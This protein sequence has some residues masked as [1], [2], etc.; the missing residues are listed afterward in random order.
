M[1]I[2]NDTLG[3]TNS[4]PTLDEMMNDEGTFVTKCVKLIATWYDYFADNNRQL[5]DD[6]YFLNIDQWSS[7]DRAARTLA[8]KPVLQINYLRPMM[9]QM[10]GEQR[11]QDP[12]PITSPKNERVS[13]EIVKIAKEVI[14]NNFYK[15]NAPVVF[16]DC[17]KYMISGGYSAIFHLMEYEPKTFNKY[18]KIIQ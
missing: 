4:Y 16:Q 1:A 7:Q 8:R 15:N 18:V 17:F 9:M 5:R 14:K 13:N 6:I 3:S 12:E 2:T 11:T 10:L